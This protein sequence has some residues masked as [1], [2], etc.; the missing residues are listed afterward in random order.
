[1]TPLSSFSDGND[2]CFSSPSRVKWSLVNDACVHAFCR[3][4][5]R[6]GNQK[7]ITELQEFCRDHA[8]AVIQKKQSARIRAKIRELVL[9]ALF[10]YFYTV[11]THFNFSNERLSRFTDAPTCTCK[12]A[13]MQISRTSSSMTGSSFLP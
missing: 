6:H 11:S 13:C 3:W 10:L 4:K 7:R 9:H 8:K 1:M 12:Q 2:A 5:R